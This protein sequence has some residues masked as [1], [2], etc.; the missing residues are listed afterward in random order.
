[1]KA[2]A[3]P[4][5]YTNSGLA[6]SDGTEISADVIVFATGFD[7]NLKDSIRKYFGDEVA[8]RIDQFFGLDDEGEVRGAWRIQRGWICVPVDTVM[9]TYSRSWSYQSWY[10]TRSVQVPVQVHSVADQSSA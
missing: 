9:L 2:G 10:S 7:I 8:D 3:V 1:V 5:N 4:T 6:F